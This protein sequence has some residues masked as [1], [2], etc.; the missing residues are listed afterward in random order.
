MRP[1]PVLLPAALLLALASPLSAQQ[2]AARDS[3]VA[4]QIRAEVD[5]ID[6]PASRP[7]YHKRAEARLLKLADSVAKYAT[8]AY[9]VDTVRVVQRDTVVIVQQGTPSDTTTPPDTSTTPDTTPTP[10]PTPTPATVGPAT[11]AALPRAEVDVT[12]PTPA[13]V[14]TV[15]AGASLQAAINAAKAGDELRLSDCATWVGNFTLPDRGDS[16]WVTIRPA[17]SV[18]GGRMTP[19]RAA[20]LCLPKILTPNNVPAIQTA[21]TAHHWRLVGLEIGGTSTASEINGIVNLGNGDRSIQTSSATTAH[22][23]VLDRVYVHGTPTQAVR[24]CINLHAGTT[25]IV[26]S[27]LADCHSNNGDSQGIVGW[28]GPGPYLIRNNRIDGGAQAVFFGG[29]DPAIPALTPSDITIQGNHITRPMTWKGVW[30][31]KTLIETKNVRRLLIEGNVIENVYADAQAGFALL[32][33]SENQ[34]CTAPYSQTADVTIRYNRIRN[35]ASGVNIAGH[36]GNCAT[37]AAARFFLHDNVF[38]PFVGSS[39][40]GIAV[41]LLSGAEDVIVAHTTFEKAMNAVVKFDGP[42]QQRLA[43]HSTVFPNSDY[44]VIGSGSGG[45]TKAL[46]AYAPGAL[47]ASNI[48]LGADV[49]PSSCTVYPATTLC[50]ATLPAVLPSGWDGQPIGADAAKVSAATAGAVVQP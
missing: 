6:R 30:T 34:L 8:T 49:Y 23:V 38:E 35:V 29:A 40:E 11:V 25:A 12:Y 43:I 31:A 39:A 7:A 15:P 32:L 42:Q 18:S 5:S 21:L 9:R 19:S 2:H 48:V 4:R 20:A 10:T 26:D 3:A 13:R 36:A 50:P 45:G 46:A 41:Q 17:G 1:H 37:V 14:V 33:K 28:N 16:G 27:W 44:G 22:H 47:F 24:R